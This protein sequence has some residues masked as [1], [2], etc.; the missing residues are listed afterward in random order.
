MAERAVGML[1]ITGPSHLRLAK[2]TN[3][4]APE[5]EDEWPWQCYV[6]EDVL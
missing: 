4:S 3:M 5:Q 6:G 1:G 2:E